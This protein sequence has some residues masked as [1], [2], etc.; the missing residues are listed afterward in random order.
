MNDVFEEQKLLKH[1]SDG[2]IFTSES[3]PY[4]SGNCNK[5]YKNDKYIYIY[6]YI[7]II[8]K[9]KACQKLELLICIIDLYFIW[10]II[11]KK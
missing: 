8:L 11:K 2:L 7:Y 9:I 6:I 3:S 5:M 10:Y 1:K 4:I